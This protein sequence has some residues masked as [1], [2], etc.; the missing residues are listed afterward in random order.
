[1][2]LPDGGKNA[3]PPP[4]LM[5]AMDK[6]NI[7][8]AWYAGDPDQ[9]SSV[10]GGAYGVPGTAAG[11]FY[12]SQT[13]AY[14]PGMIQRFARWFWAGRPAL[15]EQRAK[16]HVPM[17]SDIASISADLLFSDDVDI[18]SV[19]AATQD[20]LDD[21]MDAGLATHLRE[22]AEVCAALGG[23]YLRAV[24]DAD[25]QAMPWLT[26]VQPE[27]AIPEWR[28]GKLMAVTFWRDIQNE[29]NMVV[30]H[31]E[32]HEIGQIQHGVYVGTKD[33]LG[34]RVP[35]TDYAQLQDIADVLDGG[36]SISTGID[37]L[38]AGYVPN[39]L[40]NR[41]WRTNPD[42]IH[43]GRSDLDGVEGLMDALDETYSSWMRDIRLGKA[44]IMID[45][46]AMDTLGR[47][48]GAIMDLD[49]EV[50]VGLPLG[51]DPKD[52]I[53]QNQF[54][55]RVVEHQQTAQ[56][57][58]E[59]I[60]RSC[61]Y[62]SQSLSADDTT[63]PMTATE[64][65]ARERR[66]LSTRN[67]KIQY[68]A[69]AIRDMITVLFKLDNAIFR[70]GVSEDPPSIEFSDAVAADPKDV[71]QTLVFLNTASA[72]SKHTMIQMLHPEW[73]DHQIEAELGLMDQESQ[74][75]QQAA[76]D[77]MRAQVEIQGPALPPQKLAVANGGK[78]KADAGAKP[79]AG[80]AND[81]AAG[82]TG[83]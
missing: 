35:L 9:L 67:R 49:K 69:P 25:V 7:W 8:S 12:G 30:R 61:G 5:P 23:V 4:P 11:N 57:L 66:S 28:W 83:R 39:M 71:A 60:L 79:A 81:N 14:R 62:S 48:Q 55:I 32:R 21:Y 76:L 51:P 46:N 36:D 26:A 34:V 73:D 10:Y 78:V 20:R 77:Q 65:T 53:T 63:G 74:Q 22:G 50:F 47:G 1:M 52:L 41:I 43:F 68:W 2:P 44:R 59:Q 80:T 3:W 13:G 33:E 29:G 16:L 15:G 56:S 27:S 38:T 82:S 70:A 42:L 24:W 54:A 72:A 17:A 6:W 31:L 64:I 19:D 37:V 40:P 75:K 45:Q 58:T 18:K